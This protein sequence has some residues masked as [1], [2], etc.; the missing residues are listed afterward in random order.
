MSWLKVK[1]RRLLNRQVGMALLWTGLVIGVAVL[2]NLVGIQLVG[3]ID[4]WSRWLKDHAGYFLVWR[5][6]LYG[7]TAWSWWRMCQRLDR[8]PMPTDATKRLK[9]TEIAALLA[10]ALIEFS[11]SLRA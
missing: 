3:S 8:R 4:G 7:V 2:V 11:L 10:I 1:F 6:A 5:T 9:R